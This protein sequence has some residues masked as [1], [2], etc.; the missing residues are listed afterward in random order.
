MSNQNNSGEPP[1]KEPIPLDVSDAPAGTPSEAAPGTLLEAT[2]TSVGER[3]TSV[4]ERGNEV[5]ERGNEVGERGNE[6]GERG[7][8]VASTSVAG[9]RKNRVRRQSATAVESV[10]QMARFVLRTGKPSTDRIRNT[11][12]RQTFTDLSV[13]Y[14]A[15]GATLSDDFL[16]FPPTGYQVAEQSVRLGSGAERFER[17]AEQVMT[18]A[19]QREAGFKIRHV[20]AGTG[21]QYTGVLFDANGIPLSEQPITVVEERVGTDGTP[22]IASG[23]TATIQSPRLARLGQFLGT[24]STPVL[25]VYVVQ[26]PRRIGYAYGTTGHGDES[27]EE[28]FMLDWHDDD[29]VWLTIRTMFDKPYGLRWLT[30]PIRQYVRRDHMQRQLRALHPATG[31]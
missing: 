16:R 15:I 31:G 11:R 18:W 7:N 1:K 17:A 24:T 29:T 30:A 3:G 10:V 23:M 28:S 12:R 19:I 2:G 14:G 8:E 27:G 21:T 22:Y 13:S 26:E 5:G 9:Y 4:G 20:E 6:V 25:V